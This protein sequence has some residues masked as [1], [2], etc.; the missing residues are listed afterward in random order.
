MDENKFNIELTLKEL[1]TIL[2]GLNKLTYSKVAMLI[3]NIA[4]QYGSII[5]Q[6]KQQQ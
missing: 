4:E 5:E 2:S 1:Q 6:R 3:K